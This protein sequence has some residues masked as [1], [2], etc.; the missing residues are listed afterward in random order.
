MSYSC[1]DF[2]DNCAQNVDAYE[3]PEISAQEWEEL[4]GEE[5]DEDDEDQNLRVLAERVAR[6]M[7]DAQRFRKALQDIGELGT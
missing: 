7:S 2:V 4:T 1:S 6:A 3:V 5:R